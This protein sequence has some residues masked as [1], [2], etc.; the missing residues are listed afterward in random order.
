MMNLS[1]KQII[2]F[3]CTHSLYFLCF[4]GMVEGMPESCGTL[5]A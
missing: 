1:A 2:F 5:A 3:Q 4:W